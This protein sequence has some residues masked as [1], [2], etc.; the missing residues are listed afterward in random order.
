[1]EWSPSHSASYY[2]ALA[3]LVVASLLLARRFAKIATAR[4]LLLLGLRA[5]VLTV[6]FLILLE[7][8]RVTETRAPAQPA[9]AVYLVD[10]SRSMALE[11]PI[12][13]LDQAREAMAS[14]EAQLAVGNRPT[15]ELYGFGDLVRAFDQAGQLKAVANETRIREA[16]EQV[17]TR[18][19]G[20]LPRGVFLFS[21]GRSTETSGL[22]QIARAYRRLK[23]PIHVI[24]VG[25]SQSAGDVAIQSV[26]VPREARSGTKVPVRV[27]VR[28]RGFAGERGELRIRSLT[29][30]ASGPLASLPLT[31]ID[32]EIARELVIESDRSRGPLVVDGRRLHQ[33]RR[34]AMGRDELGRHDPRRHERV[35]HRRRGNA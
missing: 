21:D 24:P 34:G 18:I 28:S 2:L 4:S 27:V 22:A 23:V 7:P 32:G 3:A 5:A 33:L 14:A 9:K 31:L 10:C 6:L 25:S 19:T 13:R 20:A 35:C 16:L 29:Q 11:Q 26:V 12:S 8:V 30:P 15:I 17:T 1:M